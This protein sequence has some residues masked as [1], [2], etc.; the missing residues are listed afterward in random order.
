MVSP[1]RPVVFVAARRMMVNWF[2]AA[3][4]A[5]SFQKHIHECEISHRKC[6]LFDSTPHGRELSGKSIAAN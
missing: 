4:T 3:N 5:P 1:E 6:V 2:S